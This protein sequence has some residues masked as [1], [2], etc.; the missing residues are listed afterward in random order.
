MGTAKI[1]MKPRRGRDLVAAA[2]RLGCPACGRGRIFESAWRMARRCPACGLPFEREDGYF[3]GAMYVGMVT[4]SGV[5]IALYAMGRLI[6]DLTDGVLM[7]ILLAVMV[8]LPPLLWRHTRAIW[9]ALDQ[10][11]D[12]RP[13]SGGDVGP[14]GAAST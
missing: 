7:A 1:S 10:A 14:P 2:L 12:P 3:V 4:T 11:I 8:V 6:F 13:P 9:L 5:A